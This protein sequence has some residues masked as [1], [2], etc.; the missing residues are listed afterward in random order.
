MTHTFLRCLQ[1]LALGLGWLPW[2][3]LP[4]K[5]WPALR[6]KPKRGIRT[7]NGAAIMNCFGKPARRKVTLLA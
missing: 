6:T 3:I 5:L 4:P 2:A 7:P 1:N